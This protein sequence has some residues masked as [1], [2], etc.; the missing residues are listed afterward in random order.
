MQELYERLARVETN[1]ET[2]GETMTATAADVR[3]IRDHIIV[4]KAKHAFAYKALSIIGA[5]LTGA[6]GV[7]AALH[8][9]LAKI[10][11]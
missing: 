4:S 8:D 2:L 7:Y 11:G 10:F 9:Q 5:V 6:V 3:A 1:V